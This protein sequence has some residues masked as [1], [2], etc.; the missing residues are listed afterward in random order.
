MID[1]DFADYYRPDHGSRRGPQRRFHNSKARYPLQE[2]G[3]G[4][5]KSLALMW[6][7]VYQCTIVPSSNNLLLRRTITATEKGGIQD[8]FLKHVP[9]K[10]YRG[11]NGSVHCATFGNGAKLFF[12]HVRTEQDLLQ[13]QS[14]EFLFIGWDE[15]THFLYS[16]WNFMKG[17]NRCPVKFDTN[18]DPVRARM[19]GATN[20]NGIGHFW[21]KSLW[22]DKQLPLG[23][24][25]VDYNPE[26]YEAI[27]STY[28]DN[29]TYANDADY[30][31]GLESI[32]DP[33]LR[34]SWISGSWDLPSGMFFSNWDCRWDIQ[35]GRYIGRH[36][37]RL[38]EVEFEDWQERWISIDWGFAHAS[39]VLWFTRANVIDGFGK[40]KN[41]IVCYRELVVRGHN[42]ALLAEKIGKATPENEKIAYVYLS[43]DRFNRQNEEHTIADRLGDELRQFDI[44]RPERANNE[45]VGG[46][47]L[48]YTLLDTDGFVVLDTC[49]D[50]IESVPKLQRDEKN[51]EDARK[52]GNELFLDVDESLR[53]GLMSYASKAEV[54][55]EVEMDRRIKS[56]KDPTAKY[57]EYLRLQ[58]QNRGSDIE[59]NVPG[60]ALPGRR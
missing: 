38:D 33:V 35:A 26:D 47:R 17:V 57:M 18:G 1:I 36:V 24:M 6:E 46:W 14:S 27:H 43:P 34:A 2:G 37:R 30:I 15:L 25:A 13:Y 53:Y 29:A 12:G 48:V 50:V 42:E 7:A 41:V 22:I 32:T 3:K 40:K 39:A 10:L 45:R 31:S 11:W 21:T 23:E 5:G 59:L 20:T 60:P 19:A 28:A 55:R 16:M 44:P 9:R 8:L 4:G 56:I 58:N 51:L 52:E 49:R 54:P